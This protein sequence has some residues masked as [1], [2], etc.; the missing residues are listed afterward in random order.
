MM[1]ERETIP[2]DNGARER[3]T[4]QGY[5]GREGD[6]VQ[7]SDGREGDSTQRR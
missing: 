5:D 7:D 6:N 4:A 1:E 2:K 3:N